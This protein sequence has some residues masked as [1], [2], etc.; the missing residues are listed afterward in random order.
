MI[1]IILACILTAALPIIV[2]TLFFPFEKRVWRVAFAWICGQMT[3]WTGFLLISV[4]MILSNT[5]YVRVRTCYALFCGGLCLLAG[6]TACFRFFKKKKSAQP[7]GELMS[8]A[9]KGERLSKAA[10]LLWVIFAGIVL[11]QILC[12]VLLQ[13]DDGDDS[14]YVAITTFCQGDGLLYHAIP[15][16]GASTDLDARHALAPF[17]IWVAVLAETFGVS[18]ATASHLVMPIYVLLLSYLLYGLIGKRLLKAR[19]DAA[20]WML[21]L[22][23]CFAG[24]LVTFGGYSIY[25]PEQFMIVRSS[26]G[27]AVLA[28]LVIPSLILFMLCFLERLEQKARIPISIWAALLVTIVS[29]CL[30]STL[31]GFL[32]CFL[33]GIVVFCA[34]IVYRRWKIW[35]GFLLMTVIPVGM[36]AIYVILP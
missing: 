13:Y 33:L 30:C 23:L 22:F 36:A 15:Y 3:L 17:P 19:E 10:L 2:G 35:A 9:G 28:N 18:G 29:G 34:C 14:Y 32:L 25:S 11:L 20:D 26:Q 4:P 16:T 12:A 21:P 8:D 24:L 5:N 6:T 7:R 31:G 1:R 27:K